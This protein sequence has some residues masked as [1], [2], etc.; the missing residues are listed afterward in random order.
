MRDVIRRAVVR[1]LDLLDRTQRRHGIPRTQRI[2]AELGVW[3][4]PWP[5]PTPEHVL[6][7]HSP[8]CGDDLPLAKRYVRLDAPTMPLQVVR[9]RTYKTLVIAP[10]G[11]HLGNPRNMKRTEDSA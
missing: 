8:F 5:T 7:R 6:E 11:V 1:V 10:R 3:A 2:Q 4:K 9:A